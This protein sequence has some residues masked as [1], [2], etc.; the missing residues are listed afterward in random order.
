MRRSSI[1]VIAVS[2][3]APL[4]LAVAAVTQPASLPTLEP[5]TV[6]AAPIAV[7]DATL[8]AASDSANLESTLADRAGR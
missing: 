1:A 5:V 4:A 2:L 8:V 3:V 7:D 6:M